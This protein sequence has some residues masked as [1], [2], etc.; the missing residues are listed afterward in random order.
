MWK[1]M[2]FQSV[3]CVCVWCWSRICRLVHW[4]LSV[5]S[6][7]YERE[8]EKN[9]G[10]FWH[11]EHVKS[12]QTIIFGTI[13]PVRECISVVHTSR[14]RCIN[15]SFHPKFSVIWSEEKR[16]RERKTS[17][18]YEQ[19]RHERRIQKRNTPAITMQKN[20]TNCV[21]IFYFC[22]FFSV[23]LSSY[24]F[25]ILFI[26]FGVL[27]L[28]LPVVFFISSVRARFSCDLRSHCMHITHSWH[29]R[30]VASNSNSYCV[31][32]FGINFSTF[33][34]LVAVVFA[35]AAAVAGAQKKWRREEEQNLIWRQFS[36]SHST[37][38]SATIMIFKN[39]R[40]D[41]HRSANRTSAGN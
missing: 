35:I 38:T 33:E 21:C 22:I 20:N 37:S 36:T 15:R 2:N 5:S 26:S 29:G 34:S 25:F 8:M 41:A 13:L 40:R 10:E 24:F 18:E 27:S 28:L 16:E 14:V 3:V 4:F 39:R 32:V 19:R 23:I 30:T 6:F 11:R 17:Y 12:T 1:Y 31:S 7:P 9:R